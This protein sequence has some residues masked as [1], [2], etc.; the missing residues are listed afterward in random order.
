MSVF[1]I[2]KVIEEVMMKISNP[3]LRGFNPD[4]SMICVDG[5]Y[6]IATS[7]FEWW[8]GV[9]IHESEDMVHWSL[10]PSPLNR[11]DQLDLKGTCSS[12]GV[13][14]P[15]LSYSDGKFW[16]IF[17]DVKHVE[18]AFKDCVNYLV[19]AD[20]IR[21]PWSDPIRLNGVG[22]DPSLFH[23]GERKYMV[24]QTWD[25]REDH[26]PFNGITLT[27]FDTRTMQL[28]PE[29][30][31]IIWQGTKVKVTE[32]PRLYH[33]NDYYYLFAAEGGTAYEHQES[34]VR[35]KS[36]V[37]PSFEIMPDNPF[38]SNYL[39]PDSYLQKQGHGSL[40]ET[41]DGQWYYASLC[42]R[43][44]HHPQDPVHGVRGWCTLGRETSIQ[45]VD[46]TDDGWPFIVG[47]PAGQRYV[48]PP[49]PVPDEGQVDV[50]RFH[51]DFTEQTLD[52]QWNTCRVPFTSGT[53]SVGGGQLSLY[54]GQS[55]TSLDDLSLIGRRWDTFDFDIETELRFEPRSYMQMA[56]LT[57]FYND[58]F[59]SWIY[60][61]WD[62]QRQE[63]VIDVARCYDGSYRSSL[64]EAAISVPEGQ[65][66]VWFR[67][68]IRTGYY[69]YQ[70]SFD[71][72]H[73]TSIPEKFD[74]KMLSDDYV[75]QNMGG[76]FTGA[77][78]GLACVDLGG[79]RRPA[80]FKYF[81]C[82]DRS[83]ADD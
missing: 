44:W 26:N 51:D 30:E 52:P 48:E 64:K 45:K 19:T 74:A 17:T 55:L 61:T 70:F 83:D 32:G 4:P 54:G 39:T 76:F 68:I 43:P 75:A 78:S 73:F 69:W 7:T 80:T 67:G 35:T 24:Q 82:A 63:Q 1:P 14:A 41:P 49:I 11:T 25:F 28:M 71:G 8:P 53:G 58:R 16:L 22:F 10:L 34:V 46:W 72:I 66:S 77:F 31:R 37:D 60:L 65:E 56:G 36:L 62:E 59:W 5:K 12:G 33:I 81:D 18:G 79:Y 47:G 9:R 27:E 50:G 42:A 3:V 57:N 20:D 15:D 38:L 40:V 23:D 29:T 13:W 2:W 21:G 6:Y